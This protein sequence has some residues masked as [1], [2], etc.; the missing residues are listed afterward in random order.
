MAKFTRRTVSFITLAAAVLVAG[1]AL[2]AQSAGDG[3]LFRKPVGAFVVRGG[4]AAAM[5]RGDLYSFLE[6]QFTLNKGDFRSPAIGSDLLIGVASRV[7]LDFGVAVSGKKSASEFRHFVGTDNLP[8]EQTTSLTRVPLT[9]G[10]RFYLVPKGR[11]I[12]SFVWIPNKI[13]P[14]VGAGGGATWYRLHQG[15]D[16]IDFQTNDVF[17]DEFQSS[18]W[19]PTAYGVAG[20]DYSLSPRLALTGE[21]R[22]TS[23]KTQLGTDFTGFDGIDLSEFGVTVGLNVR[24]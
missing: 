14:Y 24:F 6:N 22:Y 2:H 15:G 3:F 10:A 5:A 16:F 17:N 12:G 18:G 11:T 4:Y 9:A 13:V 1:P 19:A 23:A 20:V 7:D 21:A 8:I